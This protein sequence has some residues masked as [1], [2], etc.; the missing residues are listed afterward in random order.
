MRTEQSL[1]DAYTEL[2]AS[3][4]STDELLRSLPRPAARPVARWYLMAVAAA[5]AVLVTGA[6]LLVRT[7]G[8][9]GSTGPAARI[10]MNTST[11]VAAPT[12][13]S[14]AVRTVPTA[15]THAAPTQGVAAGVPVGSAPSASAPGAVAGPTALRF[16]FAVTPN[17]TWSASL[18]EISSATE[19]GALVELTADPAVGGT[20]AVRPNGSFPE[21][22]PTTGQPVALRG[23]TTGYL[24][25]QNGPGGGSRLIW[26]YS[27]TGWASVWI[28]LGRALTAADRAKL[29]TLADHV[30][31]SPESLPRA[32]FRLG[33]LPPGLTATSY[34][35]VGS[36][37]VV[38]FRDAAGPALSVVLDPAAEH[39]CSGRPAAG[40]YESSLVLAGHTGCRV[41]AKSPDGPPVELRLD[42][43][44]GVLLVRVES[45]G[46]VGT[47][48]EQD[49]T[50]ILAK[51]VLI[52][53][54]NDS[55]TWG[56]LT[57]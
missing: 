50:R 49:L 17:A 8:A 27:A 42:V 1:R 56:D 4:P 26:P 15:V 31:P 33:Y 28:D 14:T 25:G 40:R 37:I 3:A 6:G 21:L 24:F 16:R 36:G 19:Q 43:P 38:D 45:A 48:S 29:I 53:T 55:G 34:L 13:A 18:N 12:T 32:P 5:V 10:P 44:G 54:P 51:A 23:G 47:Y 22:K 35:A 7:F 11:P 2:A 46:H 39:G 41:S 57:F 20:L 52:G 9:D 30:A